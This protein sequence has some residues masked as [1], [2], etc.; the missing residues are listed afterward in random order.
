MNAIYA[1]VFNDF[2]DFEVLDKSG[3]ENTELMVKLI[4]ND[5]VH[6]VAG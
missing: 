3:E 1:R 5:K 4:E 6:L 2:G